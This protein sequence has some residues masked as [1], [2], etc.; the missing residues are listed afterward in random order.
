M[1]VRTIGM[2]FASIVLSLLMMITACAGFE[3]TQVYEG[4]FSDVKENAWYAKEV[5]SAYELGFVKGTSETEYSPNASVT[6]AE[7]VTMA[8]RVHAEYNGKSVDENGGGK[9]Y[10]AYVKYAKD[11]G[12]ITENQ[13]DDYAREIKRFEMAEL[14]HDAMGEEYFTA[15]NDVVFIPDVP[16]G[17]FYLDKLLTLYNAG[18][19]M[20]NDEYG[21]FNPDANIKRSECA[22]IINRVALPESRIKKELSPF[23]GDNAYVLCY[24][25]GMGGSKEDINSGWV[26]DNR[27]GTAKRENSGATAIGDVSEKYATC[28]IREFNFIPSGK[29]VLETQ[30]GAIDDGAFLEYLDVKGNPVYQLKIIAGKW[31]IL[32]EGGYKS[33]G[34]DGGSI[35]VRAIIDLYNGKSTT[36]FDGNEYGTYDLLSDNILSYR[37]GVDEK[38]VGTFA[39][40]RINM[41]V[42]YGVYENFDIFGVDEAFGWKKTGLVSRSN[43][44]INFST[45]TALEKT[46]SSVSGKICAETFFLSPAGGD[47]TFDIGNVLTVESKNGKLVAGGKELY[48][49][50]KNMWHRLRVE[51][52]TKAGTANVLLNGRSVGTVNLNASEPVSKIAFEAQSLLSIDNLKIYELH[53]YS[54]YVPE[55]EARASFDDFI[56][57][58]NIC[59]LWRNGTHYGWACISAH[60]EPI[61][62]IGMYDE[63][64]PETADWEIKYMVEHGIDF[65]AFCWYA[66]SNTTPLKF[67]SMSDH[68]HDGYMYAKYSDYMKYCILWEA[69]NA[70]HFDSDYFR[71]H[72]VPYWFENYFLDPRYMTIDNQL[73]LPIFGTWQLATDEYFGTVEGV[74]KEFDYLEEVARGYGFDGFLFFSTGSSTDQLAQMGFDGAYAYNWGTDGKEYNHNVTSIINSAKNQ[75]MYTIPTIS[76]G[77]DSIPWHGERYGNMTV[78]DFEKSQV[79]VKNE[80]LP[81]YSSQYSWAD[82]FMWLST[83]NE[84]GEGTYIMPSG[85]NGFGYVDAVRDAYTFLPAEHEDVIPTLKQK[86]RI[87]HLYP[88]YAK[89][90]RRDGWYYM[91]RTEE[92]AENEPDNKLYINDINVQENAEEKYLLPPMEKDGRILFAFNP[93]AAVNFILGCHYEYRKDAKTLKIFANGHEVMFMVGSDR[94]FLDGKQLELGYAPELFDGLVMLDFEKLANDLGY[95][96]ENKNGDVYI[97]TDTYDG[98]WKI[99]AERETGVWEFNQDYDNEAFSSAHMTLV[100]RD[101]AMKM[102]TIGNTNDPISRFSENN[103]P[104]DFYTKKFTALEVRCRYRYTTQNG[105]RSNLA[106]Y[107]IT[108]RDDTYDEK[109]CLRLYLNDLDSK[110]EWVT[111]RVDLLGESNWQGAD[112]LTG[113]RFDPFNGQGEM[114]I[115]YIRFIADP[116]FVYI[117]IEERPLEIINGDA[118]SDITSFYSENATVTIV[119][120]PEDDNNHVWQIKAGTNTQYTYFRQSVRFKPYTA[121]KIEYDIKLIGSNKADGSSPDNTSFN[122]NFRYADKGAFN[123]FDHVVR[124]TSNQALSVSDGWK[125]CSATF[126]TGKIDNHER[127]EFSIY[128]NPNEDCGFSYYVDNVVVEELDEVEVEIPLVSTFS[129]SD[130][131]GDVL[132]DFDVAGEGCNVSGAFEYKVENGYLYLDVKA[133]VYD[134]QIIPKSVSFDAKDYRG[135]AIRFKTEELEA[136]NPVFQVFF[137]TDEDSSLSENK[138]EKCAHA[139]LEPDKNGYVTAVVELSKNP[140]WKGRITALRFDPANSAGKY[141][142]DKIMLVK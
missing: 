129:W 68:L 41:T 67:P 86:E 104:E 103:F 35:N 52:D 12:I 117:P 10:D 37:A 124:E 101:G 107:Y 32:T 8:V 132:Y 28:F 3:K 64:L 83:W 112:K 98:I 22:A 123:D 136:E 55:P 138:S 84:Y 38:G 27:G 50:P 25:V 126:S 127:S 113:L 119:K 53:E 17:S 74:K 133:P 26:L 114:E 140:N 54:D 7:A 93:S 110:G 109:K 94:Y 81:K 11:N 108:D 79:W 24:N 13:F 125:H 76:V 4:Q 130:S 131:E 120:D 62:V 43:N 90:L 118:E 61:P 45:G 15:V 115:D 44:Q 18:V 14:F 137:A 100:T 97:Y 5:A 82:N 141:Y 116:D 1:K 47:F 95:K 134:V 85:L 121:Y 19:V 80:Y 69:A 46:F 20:G 99:L 142:I 6:V 60:D 96:T 56:V 128:L 88:Q 51:A 139:V 111:L 49:L 39:I 70:A 2:I 31:N 78:E 87:T 33:L 122:T 9:W 16:L 29:L 57:G 23:T 58:L 48:N 42:N 77:F 59:S 66:E 135:A 30:I 92:V 106:F 72:V 34:I 73:L 89:L 91:D 65:Q 71:K 102:T 21:S 36:Y 75:K 40:S 63:G 105:G